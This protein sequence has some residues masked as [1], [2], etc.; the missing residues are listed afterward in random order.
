MTLYDLIEGE[1][2]LAL[3]VQLTKLGCIS[4]KLLRNLEIYEFYYSTCHTIREEET[5]L[6]YKIS[7]RTL[8]RVLKQ[9]NSNV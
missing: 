3:I 8:K 2:N 5:L 7:Y 6:K 9:L 1:K 4:N